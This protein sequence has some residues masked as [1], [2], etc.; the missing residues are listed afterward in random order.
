MRSKKWDRLVQIRQRGDLPS[1]LCGMLCWWIHGQTRGNMT[2]GMTVI[3]RTQRYSPPHWYISLPH[4][5]LVSLPSETELLSGIILCCLPLHHLKAKEWRIDSL[6]SVIRC[7]VSSLSFTFTFLLPCCFFTLWIYLSVLSMLVF[8]NWWAA[9]RV[10]GSFI[11]STVFL[12]AKCSPLDYLSLF[13]YT[14]TVFFLLGGECKN[15]LS[16]RKYFP[17]NSQTVWPYSLFFFFFNL[18][19]ASLLN[20]KA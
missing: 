4:R 9:A 1:I 14:S 16:R 20:S 10:N 18:Q 2:V 13:H 3:T 8:F 7:T 12:V 5:L 15:I 17:K 19:K 6:L 11:S